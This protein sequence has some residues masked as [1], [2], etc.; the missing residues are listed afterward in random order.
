MHVKLAILAFAGLITITGGTAIAQPP[1]A[2]AM[3]FQKI[4]ADLTTAMV[5]CPERIWPNYNWRTYSVLM[6]THQLSPVVWRGQTG[7][8]TSLSPLQ[9]P[10]DAFTGTFDFLTFE[11]GSA[12]S[13]FLEADDTA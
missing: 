11:G 4:G 8:V 6:K 13:V 12:V 1:S 9:I 10:R 3:D 2:Q 5:N 7:V